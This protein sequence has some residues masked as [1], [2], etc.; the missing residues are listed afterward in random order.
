[1]AITKSRSACSRVRPGRWPDLVSKVVAAQWAPNRRLAG[2]CSHRPVTSLLLPPAL[3]TTHARPADRALIARGG[4]H[5][6][7]DA[8]IKTLEQETAM[9]AAMLNGDPGPMISH[10]ADS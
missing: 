8:F 10:W 9:Q 3:S 5:M 6:T 2:I 4:W 1:M 7:D